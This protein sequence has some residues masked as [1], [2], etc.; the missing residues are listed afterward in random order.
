MNQDLVT[1]YQLMSLQEGGK[2]DFHKVISKLPGMPWAKYK[3][4]KHLPSYNFL[5][6]QTNL[7]KR[8]D[9]NDNPL[10]HSKPINRV[11]AAAYRHDLAYRDAGDDLSK[12]HQADKDMVEELESIQNPTFRERLD[13]FLVKNAMKAKL[14]VGASLPEGASLSKELH[15]PYRKPKEYLTVKV[16]NKNDIW[17]ADIMFLS[18]P[19]LKVLV[20]MDCYTRYLWVEPIPNKNAVTVKNAFEKIVKK[21]KVTPNKLW[22][23]SGTEF[24]NRIL[25]SYLKEHNIDLYSTYNEG[26]AVLAER[27]IR[28]IK[29]KMYRMR[30]DMEKKIRTWK[31]LL[32]QA[33]EKYNNTIHSSIKETPMTAYNNPDSIRDIASDNNFRHENEKI[34]NPKKHKQKKFKVGD[35]VRIFKYK[36]KFEKGHTAKWTNEIFI[37]SK[38]LNTTPITY[39]I[40]D[41]EGEP[42]LGKFYT[43]ELQLTSY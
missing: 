4:E 26:K 18:N 39:Q 30:T 37:V 19:T 16:Y 28:T 27:V 23:D 12:K 42:I 36:N 35:R 10:P 31:P 8:L 25:K 43:E 13:N 7:D 20:V 32:E 6:P 22:T 21:A 24:Y 33:V 34:A 5:G 14:A 9:A 3:G 38:V 29:E 17:T 41:E 1:A 15:K 2:I 11:D 40:E